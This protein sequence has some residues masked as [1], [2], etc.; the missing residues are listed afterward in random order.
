MFMSIL[1]VCPDHLRNYLKYFS[2]SFRLTIYTL[3]LHEKTSSIGIPRGVSPLLQN[4]KLFHNIHILIIL[5]HTS[6]V[7]GYTGRLLRLVV[8]NKQAHKIRKIVVLWIFNVVF[9]TVIFLM[10]VCVILSKIC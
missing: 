9:P 5:L 10:H 4:Y 3:R 8:S 7:R 1:G 6:V 2:D